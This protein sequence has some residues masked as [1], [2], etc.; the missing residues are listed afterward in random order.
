MKFMLIQ[1]YGGVEGVEPMTEWS[2]QEIDAHIAYQ[3]ALNDELREHG[4]LVDAQ[5]LAAP[6][7]AK[8]VKYDGV[9]A[10]VVTDGP[11]PESKELLAG[12]RIV[13]V[14][15]PE[16]APSRSR[17]KGPAAPGPEGVADRADDRGA[18]G[19]GRARARECDRRAP[20]IEDLLRDL[21]PQVLGAL[22]RR[23]GHFADAE[24]AVQEALARRG[25]AVAGAT[26]MPESPVGW[27]IAGRAPGGL[28]DS[29]A[30]RRGATAARGSRP[31]T[32][33]TPEP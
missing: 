30:Q 22:V 3:R 5:G 12:Y 32:A 23:Y 9:G 14:E 13:D 28:A 4:E 21:A 11:F 2:P 16:R 1:A 15:T 19:D 18:P 6:E 26:G 29:A 24:D 20:G 17:P 7:L 31:R 33:R 10:P 25:G 27:L 8:F